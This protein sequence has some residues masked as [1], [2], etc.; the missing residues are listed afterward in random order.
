MSVTQRP[1]TVDDLDQAWGLE[2]EAFNTVD[3][4]R[5]TPG[6]NIQG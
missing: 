2:R 5:D 6:K 1:L 4:N 3:A